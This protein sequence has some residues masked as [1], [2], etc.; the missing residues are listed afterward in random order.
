MLS[1]GAAC[2]GSG[3][4]TS[5]DAGSNG[6]GENT[7]TGE[8]GPSTGGATSDAQGSATDD[9]PSSDGRWV[10]SGDTSTLAV[11]LGTAG[12]FVILAMTGIS[13]VPT[14]A[15]TGDLGV[16]PAAASYVTGFSLVA[17]PT[18]VF[19]TSPQVTGKVYASNYA[20]PTP[21][22][23]TTAIS[24]MQLAFTD[25]AG[26]AP[27]VTGLGAGNIGGMTLGPGVYRWSTGLLIPKDV[28]LDG[29][30]ND[31]WIFQIAQSLTVSSATNVVLAGGAV[32][33]NVFWEVA[34]SAVFNTTSHFEGV[35]LSKTSVALK[36]GASITGRLLAQTAVTIDNSAVVQPAQ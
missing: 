4:A 14:S 3:G 27:D 33:K 32:A 13:T 23:L 28:T 20:E 26:R 16:S 5:T 36:T 29:S 8:G 6:D 21:A 35:L 25:A 24:D 2:G 7:S 15:I 12:G 19:S 17:D 10:D 31:V 22:N 34:G 18:N 9:G 11:N 1:V 30:A